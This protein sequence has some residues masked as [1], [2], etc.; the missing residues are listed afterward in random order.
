MDRYICPTSEVHLS[1]WSRARHR[2]RHRNLWC[3][4]S[5]AVNEPP[6]CFFCIL[7]ASTPQNKKNNDK[8]GTVGL[9]V[10]F[11]FAVV[12]VQETFHITFLDP[13]G[14][15]HN[16]ARS[17]ALLEVLN[18]SLFNHHW[19]QF[20]NYLRLQICHSIFTHTSSKHLVHRCRISVVGSQKFGS[21]N[22]HFPPKKNPC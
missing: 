1:R 10:F 16:L 19:N 9:S 11:V 20:G 12:K 5:V 17:N 22:P 8:N 4:I 2:P 7:P 13:L 21:Q 15:Y 18:L 6:P 14:G 3:P